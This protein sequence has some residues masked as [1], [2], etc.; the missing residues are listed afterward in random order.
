MPCILARI[1]AKAGP[2]M[3]APVAADVDVAR[4]TDTRRN[5]SL[6]DAQP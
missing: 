1:N 3:R 2:D 6:A 5:F 4:E